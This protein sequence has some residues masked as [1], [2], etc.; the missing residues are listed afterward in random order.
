MT[1]VR[2]APFRAARGSTVALVGLALALVAHV[3]AG[4]DVVPGAV[5]L[6]P[7]L[8]VLVGCLVAAGRAWTLGRVVAALAAVQLVVHG[9]AW[10]TSGSGSIDPRLA[11]FAPAHVS[12]HHATAGLTP[13][14]LLAH[15]AAILLAALLLARVDEVV[16]R[17]WQ[18]GRSVLGLRPVPVALPV[19][20]AVVPAPA[21]LAVRRDRALLASP[22]RGPPARVAPC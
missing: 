15:G 3:L 19:A 7:V 9:T 21:A 17:L 22:R 12:H 6:L 20:V 14:M 13:T 16:L 8:A 1:A 4:G 18:L 5:T 10:V 2:P 11:P